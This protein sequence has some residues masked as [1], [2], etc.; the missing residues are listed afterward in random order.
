VYSARYAGENASY[1]QN[2]EK[3]LFELRDSENRKARFRTVI[4]LLLDGKEYLF[5]GVAEGKII[6]EQKGMQG[7]GYDP[8]FVLEGYDK[9]FA[10]MDPKLKN[11]L[12]HRAWAVKKLADFL[13]SSNR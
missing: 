11:S 8:V 5:E 13:L 7:F 2:V 1:E 10:E 9:T 4:S 12:S 3:L 6:R